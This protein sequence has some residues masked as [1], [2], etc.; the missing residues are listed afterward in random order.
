MSTSERAAADAPE[1]APASQ[2]AEPAAEAATA[3]RDPE[4]TKA[5]ILEAAI[6]EFAAKG[7]DGARINE[8]ASRAG[9]NKRMIYHYFGGK[10]DLFVAV[11]EAVYGRIRSRER[12]LRLEDRPP[13]TAMRELVRFTWQHYRE[14]PEFLSLLNNENLH[15]ARYLRRSPRIRELHSPLVGTIRGILDR[16]AAEGVFR[17]GVDPVQLYVSIAGLGYF[18]LSNHHTLS[19]VFD[20]DLMDPAALAARVDHMTEVVLGYL[21]P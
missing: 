4:R 2:A 5:R 7:L 21:R 9:T 11:L 19:T 10:E 16:G 6:A 14:H 15:K 8:V 3:R 1:G 17:R 12:A 18:Y 13:A 20:R